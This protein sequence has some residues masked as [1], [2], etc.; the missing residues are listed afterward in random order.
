MFYTIADDL[1]FYQVLSFKKIYSNFELKLREYFYEK[2]EI[3]PENV[4]LTENF[5]FFFVKSQD[6]FKARLYLGSFR[7]YL[8]SKILII[9]AEKVLIKLLFG[10]F[11]DP[12][13]HDLK[14]LSF[15]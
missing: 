9:R 3:Y 5:I 1:I 10:F 2:T 7:K 15:H 12:Y 6:Y 4:I 14:F 8:E 13:I 11:P